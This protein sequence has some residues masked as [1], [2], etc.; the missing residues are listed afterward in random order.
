MPQPNIKISWYIGCS[1]FHYRGW[2]GAFYPE[3]LP[4]RLWFEYYN[5]RFNTLELNTTFYNFPKL[6]YLQ[7]WYERS[8]EGFVF[9]V[10]APRLITHYKKFV[11]VKSL[12]DDFY[13]VIDKG[14]R[15]K[16]G[17][18]L[19]QLPPNIQ[20]SEEKL[21][22]IL[23]TLRKG[24]INVLEFRH[25]SWW[26]SEVYAALRKSQVAFCSISH[27]EL[28]DDLV[29]TTNVFY[30]RMHG[31]P[32]LYTSRYRVNTLQ[33]MHDSVSAQGIKSAYVYFNNDVLVAAVKNAAE[34]MEIAQKDNK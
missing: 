32:R 29:Y 2:K 12:M 15:K 13:S 18:V 6:A 31:V 19:F 20:Y 9:T 16:L 4:Q 3:K 17:P 23:S 8:P 30:C 11:E 21:Q 24:Y 7:S 34:L 26:I 25:K 1:G 28:P 14:L 27:P 22:Q 33:K 5:E 10:K